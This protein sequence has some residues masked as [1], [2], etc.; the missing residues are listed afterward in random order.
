MAHNSYDLMMSLALDGELDRAE[1]EQLRLHLQTCGTCAETW[2]RMQLVNAMFSHPAHVPPP[3]NLTAQVMARVE[4]YEQR[5][6]WYPWAVGAFVLIT[7]AAAISIAAPVLFFALGLHQQL[8]SLP[9]VGTV[10][11]YALT[12]LA[13]LQE[14]GLFVLDALRDWLMRLSSD[15]VT[16]AVVLV[17]LVLASTSIGLLEWHKAIRS[18]EFAVQRA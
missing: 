10:A 6:R 17:G 13:A 5:R 2:R 15:P 11:G 12:V 4:I 18:P 9:V 8:L 16:L 14:V 1:S 7:L 3:V